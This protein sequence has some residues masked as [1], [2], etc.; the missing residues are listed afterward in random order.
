MMPDAVTMDDAVN[1]LEARA[2]RVAEEPN[3]AGG[4]RRVAKKARKKAPKKKKA[5]VAEED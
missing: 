5:G 2:A 1:M 3:G 4:K